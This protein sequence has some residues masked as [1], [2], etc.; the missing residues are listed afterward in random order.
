MPLFK[1]RKVS[2][3]SRVRSYV[4]QLEAR[5][6]LALVPEIEPNNWFDTATH[7]TLSPTGGDILTG[8]IARTGD[9]DY[10]KVEL[11][12]GELLTVNFSSANFAEAVTADI[13]LI[14]VQGNIV[15]RRHGA[16]EVQYL[17]PAAGTHYIVANA[18]ADIGIFT[19][20]YQLSVTHST[21]T[22]TPEVEPNDLPNQATIITNGTYFG[23]T[24]PSDIDYY[25]INGLTAG[26]SLAVSLVGNTPSNIQI[27]LLDSNND[28]IATDFLSQGLVRVLPSSGNYRLK[29]TGSGG[30]V[31]SYLAAISVRN[32]SGTLLTNNDFAT[33]QSLGTGPQL[34]PVAG[35]LTSLTSAQVYSFQT[36]D[37]EQINAALA[38]DPYNR[39]L[40][41]YDEQG[42]LLM[43]NVNGTVSTGTPDLSRAPGKYYLTVQALEESALG[44]YQLVFSTSSFSKQRD[45]PLFFLDFTS[46]TSHLGFDWDSSFAE[47]TAI[48]F[49]QGMFESRYGAFDVDV[50]Q[51]LPTNTTEYV[52]QGYGDFGDIGAGGW[53]G[54]YYGVRR[55]DG[56]SVVSANSM[57]VT[58][59]NYGASSI[60]N[61][62]LGHGVGLSHLRNPRGLLSYDVQQAAYPYGSGYSFVGS[63][64]YMPTNFLENSRDYLDFVLQSG[65]QI[66][67]TGANDT[68]AT[69]L[70][71]DRY[72][73]E[74]KLDYIAAPSTSAQVSGTNHLELLDFNND[75]NLDIITATSPNVMNLFLGDASGGLTYQSSLALPNG[76][77]FTGLPSDPTAVGDVDGDGITDFAVAA[78]NASGRWAYIVK[79]NLAATL[80]VAST[81]AVSASSD[82]TSLELV[83]LN[84]DARP[85]LVVGHIGNRITVGLNDGSGNFPSLT[86]IATSAP[87]IFDIAAGDVNGDTLTDLVFVGNTSG[88]LSQF[89]VLRGNG[90]GTFQPTLNYTTATIPSTIALWDYDSNGALDVV[91]GA[92]SSRQLQFFTNNGV[93]SFASTQ[94]F[95]GSADFT[96]LVVADLNGDTR[97]DLVAT[98]YNGAL[99]FLSLADGTFTDAINLPGIQ[100]SGGAVVYDANQD[101]FMDVINVDLSNASFSP[102]FGQPNDPANDRAIVIGGIATSADVDHYSFN[103]TAGQKFAIDVDAAEFQSSLDAVLTLYDAAGNLLATNNDALDRESGIDSVDPYL[104]YTF[105][106]AGTYKV[107]ISS[108]RDTV[109]DYRLK[110]TPNAAF[111]TAGPRILGAVPSGASNV[112]TRQIVLLV[113]DQLD[114]TTL[115]ANIQVVGATS[116]LRPGFATFDP[117][118]STLVWT[119]EESLPIDTYTVTL[120]GTAGGIADLRGNLLDG[121]TGG[122]FLFPQVSGNGVA[123][124]TFSYQFGISSLDNSPATFTA[125]YRRHEYNRGLFT[126]TSSD[127]LSL[128][129]VAAAKLTARGAGA[130]A[131]FN[132]ADDRFVPLDA[133]QDKLSPNT[134][135]LYTRGIPD[136][137]RYRVEGTFL[138]AVGRTIDLSSIEVLAGVEVPESVL[139]TTTEMTQTG[140]TGSYINS[141]LRGVAANTDWVGTQTIAGTR[142]DP[143]VHF[144]VDEFGSRAEVGISGGSDS[145]WD[146]FSVQWDGY[147]RVTMAGTQIYTRSNDGS[148]V[149]IDLNDDGLFEGANELLNNGWGTEHG[150][151]TS[152]ELSVPLPF[153]THK[154]RI[155]YESTTGSNEA[156]LEWLTP[157]RAGQIDN[158]A[159]GPSVIG[160]NVQ[161]N[162]TIAANLN[163]NVAV[164][165]SGAVVESTLTTDNFKLRYS[166]DPTFYDANDS[167]L[168]GLIAW[169]PA[170]HRATFQSDRLTAGYYQIELNGD[171][172]GIINSEGYLLDG[173]Y[174]D[175][176]IAGS[177]L[178]TWQNTPSGDGLPGGD[179]LASFSVSTAPQITGLT[180]DSGTSNTDRITSD[181]TL[182]LHGRA[183]AN[184]NIEV[185][186]AGAPLG[187]TSSN[188]SGDWTFDYSGISLSAGLHRFTATTTVAAVTSSPS[189]AFDVTIDNVLAAPAIPTITNDTGSSAS[190]RNTTD[191]TL[192]F[193]GTAEPGSSVTLSRVG[194][195]TLGTF[196]ATAIT[197]KWSF[198]YSATSLSD[199]V[200]NFT[201]AATDIAGNTTNTPFSVTVDNVANA[202]VILAIA[203]DTG[204]TGDRIT[205]DAQLVFSGTAEPGS[206]L[207]LRS[208]SANGTILGTTLVNGAG[209]WTFDHSATTLADGSYSYFA[210]IVDLAGN[211][212][213]STGPFNV[214]IDTVAPPLTPAMLV[215]SAASDTFFA[216]CGGAN[217]DNITADNTPT[218]TGVAA[219]GLVVEVFVDGAS[220]GTTTAAVNGTFSFT[221]P[222]IA[223]GAHNISWRAL[224]LAG[225]ATIQSPSLAISID[226]G[227]PTL[228]VIADQ[229]TNEDQTASIPLAL[230]DALQLPTNL[231]FV[232]QFADPSLVHLP[233]LS[234]DTSGGYNLVFYVPPAINM[235]GS[236]GVTITVY[237]IAGNASPQRNFTLT[238][239]PVNDPPTAIALSANTV[240]ENAA[241]ANIGIVSVSDVDLGDTHT[242]AIDDARFEIV[243]NQLRLKSGQTLDFE[244]GNPSIE[245]TA[246][247]SGGLSKT[248]VFVINVTNVNEVPTS[249]SL[250]N[251]SVPENAPAAIVGTVTVVD[252]DVGDTMDITV[253]DARFEVVGTQ[254][255]LKTGE[256]LDAD[257]TP[258]INL[259]I[260]ATDQ[261]LLSKAQ[262]FTLTVVNVNEAPTDIALSS[263]TVAENLTDVTIATISVTDSDSLPPFTFAVNDARLET[264]GSSLRF[265]A[266]QSFDFETTPSVAINITA[267][268]AGGL[269]LIKPFVITITNVNETP[270]SVHLTNNTVLENAATNTIVGNLTA[271]DPDVGDTYNI[272]VSDARFQVVA[273]QLRTNQLL[274][275]ESTP[276]IAL[277]IT[278]TDAGGLAKTQSFTITVQNVNEAP[279]AI[280]LSNHSVA[281]NAPGAIVGEVTVTDPDM[282]DVH[283]LVISDSRFEVVDGKLQ[284]KAGQSLD[285]ETEATI[286]LTL[287]ATDSG[288]LT[289]AQAFVINVTNVAEAPT[290]I[291]LSADTIIENVANVT[292]GSITVIDPEGG[293]HTFESSDNR[294]S[295]VGGNLHL[296]TPL[297][298]ESAATIS[299]TITATDATS[300]SRAQQFTINVGN[301]NEPPQLVQLLNTTIAENVFAGVIG[302][303]SFF[304]PD[305]GDTATWIVSDPRFEVV[306]NQLKL[307]TGES[308]DHESSAPQVQ[309]TVRDAAGLESSPPLYTLTV[310][311]VNE[312]P[313]AINLSSLTIGENNPGGSVGA[314]A[315]NDDDAGDAHTFIVSDARFEIVAGQLRLKAT[316]LLDYETEASIALSITATDV[317]GLSLTRELT[318]QVV[319][320]NEAPTAIFPSGDTITENT[321]AGIVTNVALTVLDPDQS[322]THTF[323]VS[324][325]R[326]EI[327]NAQLKLKVG[328]ALDFEDTAIV[329]LNITATDAGGLSV[330]LPFT[331][332]VVNVNEAP[333]GVQLS[334]MNVLENTTGAAIGLLTAVDPDFGDTHTFAVNDARFEVVGNQLKLKS[335]VALDFEATANINL[336]VT[337]LDAGGLSKVQSLLIAVDN[338]NE[339]P[340][341]LQISSLTIAENAAGAVLGNVF[342]VDPDANDLFTFAVSDP[343]FLVVAGQLRL[344]S[345]VSLDFETEPNVPLTMRVTDNG[346]LTITEPFTVQVT[347]VNEP[348]TAI[349]ASFSPVTE[350]VP[351]VA[352]G[353]LAVTDPDS[354]PPFVLSFVDPRFEI[355]GSQLRLKAGQSLNYEAG[356]SVSVNVTA[357]DVGG[358]A[359]SQAVAITVL[360]APEAPTKIQLTRERVFNNIV[361]AW[362]SEVIVSDVDRVNTHTFI[363]SDARFEVRSG[364]LYL[365]AGQVVTESAGATIPLNIQVIDAAAGGSVNQ[366][367]SLLVETGPADWQFAHQWKPNRL[368]VNA[369]GHITPLDALLII[370]WLNSEG[371]VLLDPVPGGTQAPLFLDTSGDNAISPLDA[372][373]VIN[374]LNIGAGGESEPNA[375]SPSALDAAWSEPDL[376]ADMHL[377]GWLMMW[378][379]SQREDVAARRPK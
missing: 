40:R 38:F 109:G 226:T 283:T 335:G 160:V 298:F 325:N 25:Q 205:R 192:T 75:G 131:T 231:C 371:P 93:G 164:Y 249:I 328:Q 21:Q 246:V 339:A 316:E 364:H 378:W 36:T 59:I 214:T 245:I 81:I 287:T 218:F 111:D 221:A 134:L 71:L 359:F 128:A 337:A 43:H 267:T 87:G 88:G 333:L 344:Q 156:L 321:P 211:T 165:F 217:T 281:E 266:G 92:S 248:Q 207:T 252:P 22:F 177:T 260:T 323:T 170:T 293:P 210:T 42:R 353:T 288:G 148:R 114:P 12:Q 257:V 119:A 280:E 299:L 370:I 345:N 85:D 34:L 32:V 324:D 265:K 253:S 51:T 374:F 286:N 313:T 175:S 56:D 122:A 206:T 292:I 44:P 77:V 213:V 182:V 178:W 142:I 360:D 244:A 147:L 66:V 62:E 23:G 212:S 307:K 82:L 224:D 150:G 346:G 208:G 358:L 255:K 240:A 200:Y 67:E 279:A 116:G 47:P 227:A 317:G 159:H 225:N 242:W 247:D 29:V 243:G 49:L 327:V 215:L 118:D 270:S 297:D 189:E 193:Q 152:G 138:D 274:N 340:T 91:V 320:I 101:G 144:R 376:S 379:E 83:K 349:I 129:S 276:S 86:S 347:N 169:D 76:T 264:V 304:D 183:V 99:A 54:G 228:T 139:F 261:G 112:G 26:Q 314:I 108:L 365:R 37:L 350:N 334:Q 373:E 89:S 18:G 296:A 41:L 219:A 173:E 126:F 352:I 259:T 236:T 31:A 204:T 186:L 239:T 174:L 15:A 176:Y 33:A 354:P 362:V 197:G 55:P 308:L 69:A 268:D 222:I 72:L 63:D 1:Q 258:S 96:D 300:L 194:V 120:I 46:Q 166:P 133:L 237:D 17:V 251:H 336:Q 179:Y 348:P 332:T 230:G 163:L 343:R 282:V 278:A 74:M 187:T 105:A 162:S 305:A 61:H 318:L 14:D 70:G 16:E 20:S 168:I 107:R 39:I 269:S 272:T 58:S 172:G 368:D 295:V 220:I 302:S 7:F 132:T 48:A 154:I 201:I 127:P 330:E 338:V 303:V 94:S 124:G 115:A 68:F 106:T 98:T 319:D 161:P 366:S 271:T 130:D 233:G 53:G 254:L 190:D 9:L 256:A 311:N 263:S 102:L 24:V 151:T 322:D 180:S 199:G 149:W 229:N 145:D 241:A 52:G 155:Q 19:G 35:R 275:F 291:T 290:A 250:S 357:R 285:R 185:S 351:G 3:R 143:N 202:P 4:E 306:G 167:Y 84:G 137:D 191:R 375:F 377:E 5:R 110:I 135:Y 309:L 234:T 27:S 125:S 356:E 11:S 342:V 198:D 209:A 30:V 146:N 80:A 216:A 157:D 363:V 284:L 301:V 121:E 136:A 45:V 79:G 238:I 329:V 158:V 188:A 273:G 117:I 235:S 294:F 372:V 289:K 195:G 196:T 6:L 361:A 140:L 141:S 277:D 315:I 60:L 2:R 97:T 153:G 73:A 90:N 355:V 223:D 181:T 369:D 100:G 104:T 50:T 326:F 13:L 203:D 103:A 8:T 78:S 262:A 65:R 171:A 367:F 184:A 123:G 113:N 64:S 28:T 95:K 10:F 331:V 312:A 310:T 232:P 341:N 57:N